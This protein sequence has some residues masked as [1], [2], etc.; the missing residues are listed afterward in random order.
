M[1][2]KIEK[3]PLLLYLLP[4][5][6]SEFFPIKKIEDLPQKPGVYIMK[7]AQGKVLYVGKAKNLR[8][9]VKQYFQNG[10]EG[11]GRYQIPFLLPQIQAIE[12]IIVFSEKEALLVENNLIKKH[13]PKYNIFLKDDK[14]YIA[15]RVTTFHS[16]P[17][18]ELIRYRGQPKDK[19]IYFG[20]YTSA[21]SARETLDLIQ[22]TFPLRQCSDQEFARRTRPCILYDMKRCI[23]PC[24][25][26]CSKEEYSHLVQRTIRFLQGK[27]REVIAEMRDE[28][29]KASS[30]L[31]FERA[32]HILR[33]IKHIEKTVEK[34]H[35]DRPIG[36]DADVLGIWREGNEVVI[37]QLIFRGGKL[38][39]V[40][41]YSFSHIAQEDEELFTSFL[42]Q[43]YTES[44]D[45]PREILLSLP[46][47]GTGSMEE[48]FN[49]R[50]GKKVTISHPQRG[51]K[52]HWLELARENA[53]AYFRQSKDQ[54]MIRERTLLEMQETFSLTNYPRRIECFDN[55]N[56][57]GSEPVSSLVAF[58]DGEKDKNRYRK[59]KV[60]TA[61]GSDDYGAM[62][63]VLTRRCKRGKEENDLPDLIIVDGGKSH[64]NIAKRVLGELNIITVDVIA[65]AKEEGRHDKGATAEKIFLPEVKEPIVLKTNSNI[66]FFLQKIRDEAHRVAISFQR[67]RRTKKT[68]KS[69]LEE[70]P[71]IGPKKKKALLRFFGSLKNI[72][73]ADT[74]TLCQAPGI[75]QKDAEKIKQ[76]FQK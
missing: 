47:S 41:H 74:D 17:K 63:E 50:S 24:V 45:F 22:R 12:T 37:A 13:Q 69:A 39:G 53:E 44:A 35:V 36:G 30:L 65:I 58:T 43:H 31:E 46:I 60:K 15:L 27:D 72:Q 57:S 70:I 29:Q 3:I 71:G 10:N 62:Y 16:W 67:K 48:I 4:M 9:R 40:H 38:L 75:S 42:I 2:S 66:L 7:D 20:P 73:E 61:I 8:Q 54:E 56:L 76:F 5:K 68:L 21:H 1:Q 51:D 32:A 25:N 19:G 34:Q 11:D 18:V 64:L 49:E 59:Y 14:S 33:T 28:M 55:S 6:T 26:L 23:A 52:K